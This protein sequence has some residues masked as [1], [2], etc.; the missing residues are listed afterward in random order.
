[1]MAGV[2]A[3]ISAAE[4]AERNK[5]VARENK[6]AA[7]LRT[8]IDTRAR[9]LADEPPPPDLQRA[10]DATRAARTRSAWAAHHLAQAERHRRTLTDLVAFHEDEARRLMT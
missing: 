9:Q 3:H 4:L 10:Q 7:S 5:A 2:S 1:M 8:V 6:T